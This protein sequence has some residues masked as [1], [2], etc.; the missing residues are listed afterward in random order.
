[1]TL[2]QQSM[3]QCVGLPVKRMLPNLSSHQETCVNPVR[4]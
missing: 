4:H 1:M 2:R 3:E